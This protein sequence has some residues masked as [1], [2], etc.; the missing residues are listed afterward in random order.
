MTDDSRV[1]VIF[2]MDGVL[3][4][5]ARPHFQSWAQLAEECGGSVTQD[6]FAATF[7]RQ[8]RDIV[9]VL[10]GKVSETRMHEL[11]DRKEEIYRDL[12]RDAPPIVDGACELVRSLH[13]AG[14]LLAVGS[15]GPRPNID[16]VLDAM[17]AKELIS[18][19]VSGDD[20]TRGKP[21]PQVFSLACG[22]LGISSNRCV[23]VEDAPAGVTAAHAAG[24]AAVAVLIHHPADAFEEVEGV[25]QSLSDLSVEKLVS[26]AVQ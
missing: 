9:P 14:V 12:V 21:D 16:L 5:S 18:V 25:V 17:G 1:G 8:N 10:F 7:G 3:I 20:V 19:I 2:D 13:A 6:Q 15:S 26:L 4:D 11:A 23:V 24:I 22:R